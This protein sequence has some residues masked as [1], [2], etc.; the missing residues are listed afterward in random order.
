MDEPTFTALLERVAAD[1]DVPGVLAR[2]PAAAARLTRRRRRARLVGVSTFAVLLAIA[3]ALTW[4]AGRPA[5]GP[6]GLRVVSNQGTTSVATPPPSDAQL[7]AGRWSHLPSP[8]LELRGDAYVVWTGNRLFVWGSRNRSSGHQAAP[9]R[10]ALYDPASNRWTVTAPAPAPSRTGATIIWTGTEVL[11]W[12]SQPRGDGPATSGGVAYDPATDRWRTIPGLPTPVLAQSA[13]AALSWDGHELIVVTGASPTPAGRSRITVH[14]YNPTTRRWRVLASHH[15]ARAPERLSRIDT[16]AAHGRL[17]IWLTW[18][19]R[20][21]VSRDGL[22][23]TSHGGG[24]EQFVL[25]SGQRW[26]LIEGAFTQPVVDNPILAGSFL[27]ATAGRVPCTTCQGPG[28]GPKPTLLQPV[29]GARSPGGPPWVAAPAGPIDYSTNPQAWTGRSV[30]RFNATVSVQDPN[31]HGSLAPGDLAAL[32]P[33]TGHWTKLPAAPATTTVPSLIWAGD[34]LIIFGALEENC[35]AQVD[36]KTAT[37]NLRGSG[38]A[39]APAP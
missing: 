37:P 5:N 21:D 10:G 29:T 6:K 18:L 4:A 16:V 36:C 2:Q 7:A 25:A 32:D 14:A 26:Q 11:V 19:T 22:H 27:A 30:I 17:A 12:A 33:T 39:L 3:G 23:I 13:P 24:Q 1:C 34:R 31:G 9:R 8:P 38:I 35:P 20:E 28:P 15:S